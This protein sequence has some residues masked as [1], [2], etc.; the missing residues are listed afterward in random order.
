MSLGHLWYPS[1]GITFLTNGCGGKGFTM[2][3]HLPSQLNG[4]RKSAQSSQ[5]KNSPFRND[6]EFRKALVER[7]KKE[8]AEGTY[9]TEEKWEI[10]LSRLL[11]SMDC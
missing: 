10:E 2:S 8:I 6:P 11:G 3:I 1:V 5:R 9:E 7:I 4:P